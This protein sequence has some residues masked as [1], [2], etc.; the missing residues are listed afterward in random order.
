MKRTFE[1]VR[2]SIPVGIAL[3]CFAIQ[4]AAQAETQTVKKN[5]LA[6]ERVV[7]TDLD[8]TQAQDAEVLLGRIKE[9]AYRVCGGDPRSHVGYDLMPGRVEWAFRECRDE[10][11]TRAIARVDMPQLTASFR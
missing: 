11:I 9:A 5:L 6:S 7:Y 2:A 1:L 4:P 10:A 3:A 8:L